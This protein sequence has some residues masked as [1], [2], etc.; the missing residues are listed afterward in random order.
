VPQAA[1]ELFGE[2]L[3]LAQR[4][5][6]LLA[7]QGVLRGLI[8]PR[9]A[10]RLW[11]RHLLN[12]AVVAPTLPREAKVCDVGSG[13]GLPGMAWALMRPDLDL[14][15]LEPSL[16]RSGFLEEVVADL[17]LGRVAVIRERAESHAGAMTYDVVTARAVAPLDR[18]ARLTLPLC[19]GGGELWALKG[20]SAQK[21]VAAAAATLRRLGAR[22]WSVEQFGTGVVVPPTT[23]VRVVKE[24]RGERV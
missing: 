3:P 23:V 16:R 8:G 14:T 24:P 7:E 17:A 21:E 15:L 11:E 5:V 18:L 13:A 20:A 6:E 10:D 2:R 9:E 22:Q 4:Y 12:C 1:R 19:R